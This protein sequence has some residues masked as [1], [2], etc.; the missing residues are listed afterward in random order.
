MR[1]L[2]VLVPSDGYLVYKLL[3]SRG[4]RGVLFARDFMGVQKY[5]FL[6]RFM[7]IFSTQFY[8]LFYTLPN[9]DRVDGVNN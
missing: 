3:Y 7:N 1:S 4:K 9:K 2:V 6:H 8:T 5:G